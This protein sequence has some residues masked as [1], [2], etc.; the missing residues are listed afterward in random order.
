M[1]FVERT[2]I[3]VHHRSTR[4]IR[5]LKGVR[6]NKTE[7]MLILQFSFLF[8]LF[9]SSC[10]VTQPPVFSDDCS[11]PCWRKIEPGKTT[12][13]EALAIVGNMTD[14]DKET[15]G[16]ASTNRYI[17][18]G[19]IDF[20]LKTGENVNIYLLDDVVSVIEFDR[21]KGIATFGNC[22]GEFGDPDFVILTNR[23]GPGGFPFLPTSAMHTWFYALNPK[24]VFH[25]HMIPSNRLTKKIPCPPKQR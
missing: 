3:P 20:Y 11:A 21:Q 6:M 24:K 15:V 4:D 19:Y 25:F 16:T 17:F 5:S 7:R 14:V 1:P 13:E 18:S 8:I 9:S 2:K 22:I 10:T 12:L 23:L